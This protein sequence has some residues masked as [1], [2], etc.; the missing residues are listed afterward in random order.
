M[1]EVITSVYR[2]VV[3]S[4]EVGDRRR[5][6]SLIN[7]WLGGEAAKCA[8]GTHRY[9]SKLPKSRFYM[10][11]CCLPRGIGPYGHRRAMAN[12]SLTPRSQHA[13]S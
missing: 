7:G 10:F 8:P 1:G 11:L 9:V 2:T 13:G 12:Y 4:R 5:R 3:S 6:L